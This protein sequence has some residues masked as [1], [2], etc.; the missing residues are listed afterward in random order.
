[1]QLIES[2]MQVHPTSDDNSA[3]FILPDSPS[4]E[5]AQRKRYAVEIIVFSRIQLFHVYCEFNN[6][7]QLVSLVLLTSFS[8]FQ[9]SAYTHHQPLV[10]HLILKHLHLKQT[11]LMIKMVIIL[12]MLTRSSSSNSLTQ[13]YHARVDWVPIRIF[14]GS[15]PFVK[16]LSPFLSKNF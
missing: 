12:C 9:W 11:N 5:A 3:D 7:S 10:H 6:S 13:S 8:W 15:C 14:W 4:K 1:M 2:P 16:S